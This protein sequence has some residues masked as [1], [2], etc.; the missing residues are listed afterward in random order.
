MELLTGQR[1]HGRRLLLL[2][3]QPEKTPAEI[4]PTHQ[5]SYMW[6]EH[7]GPCLLKRDR[8]VTC[9]IQ[10]WSD[11]SDSVLRHCFSTTKWCVFLDNNINTYT[12]A[13]ICYIGK[14]I[15][16]VP[17]ITVWTFLNQKLW[18]NGEVRAKLNARTEAYNDWWFRDLVI[19]RRTK[20]PGMRSG[21]LLAVLRNNMGTKWSLT[22][23]TKNYYRLQ[24]KNQ[25]CSL[26]WT[27][28]L[29]GLHDSG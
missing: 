25:Q 9:T 16:D 12:D 26:R 24:K 14:C 21:E 6:W 5:L 22:I 27:E 8:L 17:R 15:D 18:V 3:H 13:V 1:P 11:Q 2:W 7:T 20:N 29:L 10:Q 4:S 19:W 23:R 28:H